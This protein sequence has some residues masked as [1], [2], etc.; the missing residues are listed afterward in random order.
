MGKADFSSIRELPDAVRLEELLPIGLMNHPGKPIHDSMAQSDGARLAEFPTIEE[1]VRRPESTYAFRNDE[2]EEWRVAADQIVRLEARSVA[3]LESPKDVETRT[4]RWS[5][6]WRTGLSAWTGDVDQLVGFWVREARDTRSTAAWWSRAEVEAAADLDLAVWLPSWSAWRRVPRQ[7]AQAAPTPPPLPAPVPLSS[8]VD[9]FFERTRGPSADATGGLKQAAKHYE[10]ELR[11]LEAVHFV[12]RDDVHHY[13]RVWGENRWPDRRAA[14]TAASWPHGDAQPN[15]ESQASVVFVKGP[16]SSLEAFYKWMRFVEDPMYPVLHDIEWRKER[17][18]SEKFVSM[19]AGRKATPEYEPAACGHPSMLVSPAPGVAVAVVFAVDLRSTREVLLDALAR[20]SSGGNVPEWV[21]RLTEPYHHVLAKDAGWALADPRV[22][23]RAWVPKR[24]TH[25]DINLYVNFRDRTWPAV[26]RARRWTATDRDGDIERVPYVRAR[27]LQDRSSNHNVTFE[28]R[29]SPDFLRTRLPIESR[30]RVNFRPVGGR[31]DTYIGL[32]DG[33]HAFYVDATERVLATNM[34]QSCGFELLD[35]LQP[36]D[37][38]NVAQDDTGHYFWQDFLVQ[39]GLRECLTNDAMQIDVPATRHHGFRKV[40]ERLVECEAQQRGPAILLGGVEIA[41]IAP[42]G[43]LRLADSTPITPKDYTQFDP[44]VFNLRVFRSILKS[45][46]ACC[47]ALSTQ[48][49]R[50]RDHWHGDRNW[51]PFCDADCALKIIDR[52]L[53]DLP[54]VELARRDVLLQM[55]GKYGDGWGPLPGVHIGSSTRR[56][57]LCP[58]YRGEYRKHSIPWNE[59][60]RQFEFLVGW[61]RETL[62]VIH[63]SPAH[64][65]GRNP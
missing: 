27:L 33:A 46:P 55:T 43:V 47:R 32:I 23:W 28:H 22:G 5:D 25:R 8:F 6:A 57:S 44:V 56:E 20:P 34:R 12:D 37:P 62:Q 51:L 45:A 10:K 2:G 58:D 3:W 39:A 59:P 48:L 4:A 14:S 42:S 65:E 30:D 64:P 15:T 61:I 13:L 50:L 40:L 31:S 7:F 18:D 54:P 38:G 36:T 9:K 49:E 11:Q 1:S 53:K 29:L 35:N 24:S 16:D 60:A 21:P 52:L 63:H 41:R 17:N 26:Q 19:V